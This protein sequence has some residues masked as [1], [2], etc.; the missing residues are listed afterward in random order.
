MIEGEVENDILRRAYELISKSEDGLIQSD[1]WKKLGISS[2]KGSQV[3]RELV[4]KDLIEREKVLHGGRWTYR[5]CLKKR[6]GR[7]DLIREL[8]CLRCPFESRCSKEDA[9]YLITCKHLEDWVIKVYRENIGGKSSG[10][11]K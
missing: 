3:V 4:E 11:E 9:R 7:I 6:E 2:R 5:L 10:E 8:Y 1:L